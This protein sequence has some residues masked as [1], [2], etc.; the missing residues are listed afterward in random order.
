[1]SPEKE[2]DERQQ[3]LSLVHICAI[4]DGDDWIVQFSLV[5]NRARAMAYRM[6][7]YLPA[8]MR[9]YQ[10]VTQTWRITLSGLLFMSPYWDEMA[11]LC[12]KAIDE[13][14][15][16][17]EY[18]SRESRDPSDVSPEIARAFASLHLDPSAPP[19]VIQAV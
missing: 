9:S 2:E 3:L 19:D 1:M 11:C 18:S 4:Q 6:A 15:P 14:E 7:L 10:P 16:I 8:H 12:G 17:T 5:D 13:I